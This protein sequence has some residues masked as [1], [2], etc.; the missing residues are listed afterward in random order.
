MCLAARLQCMSIFLP[1]RE[2]RCEDIDAWI[3]TGLVWCSRRSVLLTLHSMVAHSNQ[4]Y[5]LIILQLI[6][7]FNPY[8]SK[9]FFRLNEKFFLSCFQPIILEE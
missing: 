7:I 2:W 3:L 8:G 6:T 4:R 9:L 5:S 1:I